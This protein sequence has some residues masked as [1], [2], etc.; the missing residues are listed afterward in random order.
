MWLRTESK[1]AGLGQA[2]GGVPGEGDYDT[3]DNSPFFTQTEITD[4]TGVVP[5]QERVAG[6]YET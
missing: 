2:G 3:A 5:G 6:L 1:E 4:H